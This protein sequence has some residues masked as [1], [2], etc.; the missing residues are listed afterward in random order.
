[1]TAARVDHAGEAGWEYG[2]FSHLKQSV[3]GIADTPEAVKL[4]R[5][6]TWSDDDWTPD[7]LVKRAKAGEWTPVAAALGVDTP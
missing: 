5:S 1:M 3:D 6:K 2:A 4:G 7:V